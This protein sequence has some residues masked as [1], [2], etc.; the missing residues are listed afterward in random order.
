MATV[1]RCPHLRQASLA[2]RRD[3]ARGQA[4]ACAR[5]CWARL[6]IRRGHDGPLVVRMLET[7]AA[8]GPRARA[9][10]RRRSAARSPS[11]SMTTPD[12]V[13]RTM[14]PRARLVAVRWTKGRNPTPWTSPHTSIRRARCG[15]RG[16]IRFRPRGFR[17]LLVLR[18]QLRPDP[19]GDQRSAAIRARVL[20]ERTRG[21]R[22]VCARRPRDARAAWRTPC[23]TRP[24]AMRACA[25]RCRRCRRARSSR[26]AP[27]MSRDPSRCAAFA[28]SS[29]I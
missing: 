8:A 22:R 21:R 23:G 24:G 17:R 1:T 19:A 11:A 9:H 25:S 29:P 15:H 12:A 14:P 2:D 5:R 10:P 28:R 16:M 26:S 3:P 4:C 13:F 7:R 27:A 18:A 20:R 6:R